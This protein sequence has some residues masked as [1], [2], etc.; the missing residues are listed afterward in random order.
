MIRPLQHW[1]GQRPP[2]VRLSA[3][4][5]AIIMA[6][7]LIFS[8]ALYQLSVGQLAQ[9]LKQ[10][11]TRLRSIY[12]ATVL[13]PV[14]PRQIEYELAAGKRRLAW[15]LFYFN[16]F[17]LAAGTGLSYWLARRTLQPIET[18]LLAQARFAADASHELRT[19]LAAMQTG[20]EV[21]LRDPKLSRDDA[22]ALLHSNLEEVAKLRD[23]ADGLLRLARSEQAS[24]PQTRVELA[25]IARDAAER[26]ASIAAGRHI[27]LNNQVDSPGPATTGDATALAE[28]VVIL[29]DNAVK[30]SPTHTTVTISAWTDRGSAQLAIADQGCGIAPED[31]PCIFDRFYRADPSRSAANVPGNGLG[32]SLAHQ[33]VEL[34]HG[35]IHVAST[36]GQGSTFTIRLPAAS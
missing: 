7:S 14:N 5:M 35:S 10:Q 27:K 29:L 9:S 2:A 16:G 25:A 21:A 8:I 11:Y 23:L 22:A 12:G 18:A 34:H 3:A 6:I 20:I 26:V 32:L 24:L 19:P 28:L 33:I 15:Q 1:W 17:I 4:Y 30:Y 36:V 13:I 31:L